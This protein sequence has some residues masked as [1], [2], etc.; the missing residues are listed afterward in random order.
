[1]YVGACTEFYNAILGV[2]TIRLPDNNFPSMDKDTIKYL[3]IV[4]SYW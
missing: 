4:K 2:Y 1:M 3:F